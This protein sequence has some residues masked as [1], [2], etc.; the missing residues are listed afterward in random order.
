MVFVVNFKLL[1]KINNMGKKIKLK[2]IVLG[3]QFSGKSSILRRYK[4]NDFILNNYSTIG[5]DFIISDV[6]HNN[7]EYFS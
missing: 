3:D 6:N 1:Y 2:L 5:V 4:N 7:N